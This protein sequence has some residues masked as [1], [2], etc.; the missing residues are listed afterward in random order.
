MAKYTG[1]ESILA[2]ESA[3]PG[4]YTTIAQVRDVTGPGL[5]QAAVEVTARDSSKWREFRGG[6]R[7]GGEVTFDMLYDPTV[8]THAATP[9]PGLVNL[10]TT[11]TARNFR[12]T[13]A[14][15]TNTATFSALV[16]AFT[17]KSPLGDAMTAD[18]TL[19]VSG[20]V[21]FA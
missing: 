20:A 15:A 18:V 4:I 12:L 13:F 8:A 17:P 21:T 5:Q 9:A 3:T 14:N 7:D 6:L 2:V 11:G 19:K 1:Y 10:L 16:T